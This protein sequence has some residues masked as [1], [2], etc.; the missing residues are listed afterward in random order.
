[1]KK[2]GRLTACCLTFILCQSLCAQRVNTPLF[3]EDYTWDLDRFIDLDS[4]SLNLHYTIKESSERNFQ[5]LNPVTKLNFNTEYPVGYND[6]AVW[7]GRGFNGELHFGV[8]GTIG[9]LEYTF[10]PVAYFAQNRSYVLHEQIGTAHPMNYQFN[11]Y[12]NIFFY[13][14]WVQRYGSTT[15]QS[16]HS[17]QSEIKLSKFGFQIAFGTQN[18]KVGPAS[19]FPIILSNN[20]PGMPKLNIGT[21]G[22]Q[23]IKLGKFKPGKLEFNVIYGRM[24]ESDYFD[25]IADNNKRFFSSY[26]L[27][28]QPSF[29]KN[30]TIGFNKVQYKQKRYQ[31]SMDWL[32][33][34]YSGDEPTQIINGDTLRSENDFFDLMASVSMEWRFPS[35]GFRAYAEYALNDK[36]GSRIRYMVEPEHSRAYLV[37]FQK[38]FEMDKV[39]FLLAYEHI[40]LSRN[41]TY[42]WR[43]EPTYYTHGFNRQGYTN[44]GQV[45]GA[46]IGPGANADQLDLKF[47]IPNSGLVFGA[48]GRRIEFNKDYFLTNDPDFS[49]H[50]AEY[51]TGATVF[52]ERNDL[53]YG[54]EGSYSYDHNRYFIQKNDVDNFYFGLSIQYK[55][56]P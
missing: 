14:D 19:M 35:V 34:F 8:S 31:D 4:S 1:M 25:N 21:D 45:I 37:G 50:D 32:A 5:V 28:Y 27:G 16:I 2:Y 48:F 11:R 26:F 47:T 12:D 49:K 43:A 38:L 13:I 24:Y 56:L 53:I 33:V 46:G 6:G 20:G 39:N 23:E 55:V 29:V 17:G 51:T 30:L 36:N 54:F 42:M 52:W 9:M 44:N 7:R 22:P 41:H 3:V 15:Y 40:N 18:Y 10:Q